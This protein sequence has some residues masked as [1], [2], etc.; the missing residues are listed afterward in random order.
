MQARGTRVDGV[1]VGTERARDR[2]GMRERR[3]E[4][5]IFLVIGPFTKT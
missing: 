1:A 4:E 5:C 3:V 2:K